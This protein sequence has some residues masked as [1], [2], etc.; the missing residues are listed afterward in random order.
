MSERIIVYEA[1]P[2]DLQAARAI[3]GEPLMRHGVKG[4][5]WL[6]CLGN[7]LQ[8]A[9]AACLWRYEKEAKF[10]LRV[11]KA[12]RRQGVGKEL[13][14][15]I[16]K[17]AQELGIEK[18]RLLWTVNKEDAGKFLEAVQFQPE[19]C[20]TTYESTITQSLKVVQP[21]YNYLEKRSSIPNDVEII[22]LIEAEKRGLLLSS[23]HLVAKELGG[24]P[25]RLIL[26]MQGKTKDAF[27]RENSLILLHKNEL[28][29]ILL[30][31]YLQENL[32]WLAEAI[33]V[34]RNYRGYWANVYIRQIWF[35][36]TILT[37]K[38]DRLL[39]DV[40]DDYYDTAKFSRRLGAK[41]IAH[42]YMY[43]FSVLP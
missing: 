9:G 25:P 27:T 36:T 41:A 18:L 16:I 24:L 33:V 37:G 13:I 5:V 35:K 30:S 34:N 6:A 11:V 12:R 20:I 1:T 43:Q 7:G 4:K 3:L 21:I 19:Y 17:T 14:K 39:F 2:H 8:I 40:R 10:W 42:K 28:I 31:R 29:A 15:P 32:G 22:N 38:S 26:R 23:A